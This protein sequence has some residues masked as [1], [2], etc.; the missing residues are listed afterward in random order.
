MPVSTTIAQVFACETIDG[1]QFLRAQMTQTCDP[2][3]AR[4]Q[5]WKTFAVIMLFV[6]PIGFPLFLICLLLPQRTRIRELMS[7][8][9][10]QSSIV[11]RSVTVLE[12]GG[13][14]RDSNYE[15]TNLIAKYK[16]GKA[17][18]VAFDRQRRLPAFF[19]GSLLFTT[20]LV[21]NNSLPVSAMLFEDP[22][23]YSQLAFVLCILPGLTIAGLAV[24]P[25]DE[26]IIRKMMKPMVFLCIVLGCSNLIR[27]ARIFSASF[28]EEDRDC[29]DYRDADVPCWI[30]VINVANFVLLATLLWEI[31]ARRI[32]MSL[33]T[34]RDV[35]GRL[36]LLWSLWAKFLIGY[37]ALNTWFHLHYLFY[38]EGRSLLNSSTSIV[39]VL[40][41]V[42]PAAFGKVAYTK[43]LYTGLQSWL[44]HLGSITDAMAIAALMSHGDGTLEEVTHNAKE[45]LR[46]VQFSSMNESDFDLTESSPSQEKFARSV[47]CSPR[48]IDLFISHS[49]RDP[50]ATKWNALASYC[51]AFSK[52]HNREARLWVDA[53]CLDP[54]SEPEPQFHPVFLMASER[55]VVLLGPTFMARLWCVAELFLFVEAGG[56]PSSIKIL[57]IEGCALSADEVDAAACEC[58][59]EPDRLAME[60][61]ITACGSTSN[62]NHR[63]RAILRDVVAQ[64]GQDNGSDAVVGIP[65]SRRL[66]GTISLTDHL[67]HLLRQFDKYKPNCWYFNVLLLAVRLLKTSMMTLF[68]RQDTQVRIFR[69]FVT[70]TD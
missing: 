64:L 18:G 29:I 38:A 14:Q 10:R 32:F 36:E 57:P 24:L 17:A 1:E 49:W 12:L 39:L 66:S 35:G 9:D 20:G 70:T 34:K 48:D 4:R 60:K 21:L 62:F 27:A 42:A 68:A 69:L 30:S 6:Y 67:S 26:E 54:D 59:A 63:V 31:V 33:W 56:S 47:H 15:E 11:R 44:A 52:K 3:S 46:Y 16:Q 61:M 22:S 25:G 53:F 58:F 28:V 13:M 7:E 5:S 45:K 43:K 55:L 41:S 40:S 2:S 37:A 8:A 23:R 65:R 50:P 51:D 19:V